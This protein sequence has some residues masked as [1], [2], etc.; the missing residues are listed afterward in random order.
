MAPDLQ[1]R[2]APEIEEALGRVAFERPAFGRVRV[3]NE[4]LKRNTMSHRPASAG[5]RW[6][7]KS[8]PLVPE[9]H[10]AGG[11]AN[12]RR[13]SGRHSDCVLLHL[14]PRAHDH[15]AESDSR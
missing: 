4:F 7:P 3:G 15:A 13:D 12:T 11:M 10:S 6:T 8:R 9:T 1:N 14:R 5:P 2:T